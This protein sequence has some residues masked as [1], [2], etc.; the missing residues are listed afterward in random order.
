MDERRY[1]CEHC[2]E[3]ILQTLYYQ[4]KKKFYSVE[5]KTWI[6]SSEDDF[7]PQQQDDFCFPLDSESAIEPPEGQP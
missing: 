1:Y 5:S 3:R 4:H 2:G 7:K 6:S